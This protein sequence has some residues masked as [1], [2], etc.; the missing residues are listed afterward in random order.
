MTVPKFTADD[1]FNEYDKAVSDLL[2]YIAYI[3]TDDIYTDAEEY[4]SRTLVIRN[5]CELAGKVVEG[6]CISRKQVKDALAGYG[7]PTE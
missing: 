3:G 5:L 6:A 2:L 7:E 1:A 4:S